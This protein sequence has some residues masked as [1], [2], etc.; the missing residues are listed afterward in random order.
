MLVGSP[1]DVE[2][3]GV[4]GVDGDARDAAV[5][6]ADDEPVAGRRPIAAQRQT[7][8]SHVQRRPFR[9]LLPNSKRKIKR[10]ENSFAYDR[11]CLLAS[12][13]ATSFAYYL[14]D[15]KKELT[16]HGITQMTGNR[17]SSIRNYTSIDRP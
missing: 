11:L 10:K 2:T 5:R 3:R 8:F 7:P 1:P 6:V 13:Q 17:C 4:G 9:R 15:K 14:V 12:L 16:P